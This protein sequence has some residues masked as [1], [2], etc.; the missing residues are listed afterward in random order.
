MPVSLQLSEEQLE[1]TTAL[2]MLNA[3]AFL[4]FL[5]Q[6]QVSPQITH[7]PNES[8]VPRLTRH[9]LQQEG[10]EM[11]SRA[12]YS[13]TGVAS[14]PVDKGLGLEKI[15][16]ERNRE[17]LCKNKACPKL[18][19]PSTALCFHV[20]FMSAVGGQAMHDLVG[21]MHFIR[22]GEFRQD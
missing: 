4:V 5:A 3:K 21:D 12:C 17:S 2:F 8:L 18:I 6:L 15:P 20:A 9:H 10:A 14:K 13:D 22:R 16:R 1:Q 7:F 19:F 11:L